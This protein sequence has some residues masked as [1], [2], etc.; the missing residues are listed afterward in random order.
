MI[1]QFQQNQKI[2]IIHFVKASTGC[3]FEN[4]YGVARKCMALGTLHAEW[5]L[6]Y[7]IKLHT[8]SGITQALR[9]SI[10]PSGVGGQKDT[11][12]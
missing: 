10:R 12:N 5:E 1:L 8:A 4:T 11:A 9:A 6:R 3:K 7:C 2:L